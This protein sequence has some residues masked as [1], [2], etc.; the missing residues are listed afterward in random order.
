MSIISSLHTDLIF[1]KVQ[2]KDGQI[3]LSNTR[4]FNL[5]CLSL[6][7]NR[8]LIFER[9]MWSVFPVWSDIK[10]IALRK[11]YWKQC[12]QLVIGEK[13]INMKIFLF[14]RLRTIYLFHGVNIIFKWIFELRSF[15]I[16]PNLYVLVIIAWIFLHLK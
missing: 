8:R 11:K 4:V 1:S 10:Y 12:V 13:T 5:F 7:G 9:N 15:F 6:W 14:L 3:T 2:R 16:I